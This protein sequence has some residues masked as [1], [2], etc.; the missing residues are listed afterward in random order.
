MLP[1]IWSLRFRL[2]SRRDEGR[3]I[4]RYITPLTLLFLTV[5]SSC[6]VPTISYIAEPIYQRGTGDTLEFEHNPENDSQDFKG[7]DL[8]YKIYN[9]NDTDSIDSD[10]SYIE[11]ADT[12][13][14]S[15]LVVRNFLRM[16]RTDSGEPGGTGQREPPVLPVSLGARDSSFT[17]LVDF[18]AAEGTVVTRNP[19]ESETEVFLYRQNVLLTD[20]TPA[21]EFDRFLDPDAFQYIPGAPETENDADLA[22]MLGGEEYDETNT[23]EAAV[24]VIA[25]GI[26]AT[27]FQQIYSIPIHLGTVRLE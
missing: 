2:R 9:A 27:N 22:E 4:A 19:G 23:Y 10:R 3:G 18:S 25:Y 8:Y 14:T 21:T 16:V 24:A 20:Q 26:D 15:R 5:G 13:G 6:G 11:G 17:V 1:K 7:Y 12:P